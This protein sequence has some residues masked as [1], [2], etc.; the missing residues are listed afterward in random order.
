MEVVK[1]EKYHPFLFQPLPHSWYKIAVCAKNV[2]FAGMLVRQR[3]HKL[4][5]CCH[6]LTRSLL[7][8]NSNIK[9]WFKEYLDCMSLPQKLRIIQSAISL[10]LLMNCFSQPSR[11]YLLTEQEAKVIV[12]SALKNSPVIDG[13]NDLFVQYMDCKTCPRDL[14]QF[15]LDKINKGHTDIPR[16][17]KGGAGGLLM[18]VFGADKTPASY[19]AAWEL[20]RRMEKI[21]SRDL[22][23]TTSSEAMRKAMK[24][25]KIALLPILEGATRLNNDIA[26]LRKYYGWGLRSVTFAYQTNG[27]ADGSDDKP[28]HNGISN[29]GKQMVYEMNR[30]GVL[31][32][33]SHISEKAMHAILDI[34]KAPVIFS[35]S[36][37]KALCDVNRNVSD[38]VLQRLKQ[39][40]GLIM[41]TFVPYFVKKEHSNW[42][43]A[44]DTIYYKAKALY[45]HDKTKMDSLMDQWEKDN[46]QPVINVADMADHFDYVKQLI[47]IEHIGIAGDFD[48]IQYT[49][50][51]LENTSTYPNLLVELA[52]RGW[53]A[54]E[55]EKINSGNFLRVFE[56]V[57]KGS[58]LL[59]GK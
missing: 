23:I 39:N 30:L 32:D 31:I 16:L 26:T 15:P 5:E 18:N 55:L 19:A 43:D 41:L 45:P 25:G 17:R 2:A 48:G 20:L 13:H 24:Q 27:L 50:T 49:I 29:A 1:P 46:P 47:G 14:K 11:N 44:G 21:Y 51:G 35:H 7:L 34:T 12:D 42:L 4:M 8:L 52:R 6:N 40:R 56:E 53:T 36:N 59:K 38:S 54:D 3:L 22:K 57:E 9:C 33:M 58:R 28:R 10:L 37:A